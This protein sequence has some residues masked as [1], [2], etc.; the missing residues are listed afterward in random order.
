MALQCGDWFKANADGLWFWVPVCALVNLPLEGIRLI[1]SHV[2]HPRLLLWINKYP[3]ELKSGSRLKDVKLRRG[4]KKTQKTTAKSP[5]AVSKVLCGMC[6][7]V[8]PMSTLSFFQLES[9]IW[10]KRKVTW[11]GC[12]P[13]E[14][15]PSKRLPR[16]SRLKGGSPLGAIL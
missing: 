8:A 1:K 15:P 6:S 4:K 5:T 10:E 11:H 3:R 13:E 7:Y 16:N 9:G 12:G 14:M 2:L